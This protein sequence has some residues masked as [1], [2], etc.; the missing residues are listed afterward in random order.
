MK[1]RSVCSG[2]RPRFRD[3][4]LKSCPQSGLKGWRCL[5]ACRVCVFL[6][7]SL[8]KKMKK[9]KKAFL[10]FSLINRMLDHSKIT[11]APCQK[12]IAV[13]FIENIAVDRKNVRF[14]EGFL[15][16]TVLAIYKPCLCFENVLT[17]RDVPKSLTLTG[18]CWCIKEHCETYLIILQKIIWFFTWFLFSLLFMCGSFI[19]ACD[20]FSHV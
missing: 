19:F 11:G 1:Q 5:E 15:N 20:S 12:V 16:I 2:S 8:K 14:L 18:Y 10:K 13:N 4:G 6:I 3:F 9:K 7:S 17:I